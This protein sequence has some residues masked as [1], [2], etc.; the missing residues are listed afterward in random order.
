MKRLFV[1]HLTVSVWPFVLVFPGEWLFLAAYREAALPQQSSS[2]VVFGTLLFLLLS[3]LVAAAVAAAW[4]R[5]GATRRWPRS[6]P[7]SLTG[8]ALATLLSSWTTLGAGLLL[9][10][11]YESPMAFLLLLPLSRFP[12]IVVMA[13][14]VDQVNDGRRASSHLTGEVSARL[15]QAQRMNALLESAQQQVATDSGRLL[16]LEVQ[17]PLRALMARAEGLADADFANELDRFVDERLRP[18]AHRLHPVSVRL[19]LIQALRSLDPGMVIDASPAIERLDVNGELLDEDVRLQLYRWARQCREEGRATRIAF[20][21]RARTLEVSAHPVR[22]APLLDPVQI[23]A[24]LRLAGRGVV[25]APLRGQ[26]PDLEDLIHN[27]RGGVRP[28]RTRRSWVDVLTV[29]LPGAVSMV[30]LISLSS[31]FVQLMLFTW[32]LTWGAVLTA[33]AW[34]VAPV[35]VAALFSLLPPPSRTL[36]GVWRVC[37]EWVLI[38]IAAAGAFR[39][40]TQ[41]FTTAQTLSDAWGLSMFRAV[42]RFTLPGLALVV[43]HGLQVT[44]RRAL[45]KANAAWD[46]EVERQAEILAVSRRLDR[47]VAEALHRNVQ[48]RLAAAVVMARLGQRQEAWAQVVDMAEFEIPG[49]LSR[50]D[51]ASGRDE[52][53]L[54]SPPEGLVVREIVHALDLPEPVLVDVQRAVSEIALN[55]VRH[56][57]ASRLMIELDRDGDLLRLRCTDNGSG[58]LVTAT[59]GLGSRLLDEIADRHNGGWSLASTPNGCV[60]RM[61]LFVTPVRR[62]VVTS[63]S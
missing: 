3:L 49:L 56:G 62:A 10:G 59:P 37:S 51:E 38:A 30:A 42:Y 63:M 50:L 46:L 33:T 32:P 35:V 53:L 26:A 15:L 9:F 7:G 60:V 23:V 39:L 13:I 57:G 28:V 54:P 41:I 36:W 19:G 27:V 40:S 14:V 45:D 21:M 52:A 16:R 43:A 6:L 58:S 20:V 1:R 24:G 4:N 18:L 25:V 17:E 34:V 61:D 44:L 31:F 55:A 12:S 11:S 47:D 29:P 8:Y 5:F 22:L 2:V 48:G